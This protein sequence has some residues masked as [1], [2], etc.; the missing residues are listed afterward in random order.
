MALPFSAE[1]SLTFPYSIYPYCVPIVLSYCPHSYCPCHIQQSLLSSFQCMQSFEA[2]MAN[3]SKVIG[4]LLNQYSMKYALDCKA[5]LVVAL[6]TIWRQ[7]DRE[8]VPRA[9]QPPLYLVL[10]PDAALGSLAGGHT[11][12]PAICWA[13]HPLAF[14]ASMRYSPAVQIVCVRDIFVWLLNTFSAPK[15]A[16]FGCQESREVWHG[17]EAHQDQ[18]SPSSTQPQPQS[19]VSWD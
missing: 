8:M 2:L 6:S 17:D 7:P 10:L 9:R 13:K 5:R 19:F 15:L 11:E 16:F 3:G 4:G 12:I 14:D 18:A 1:G